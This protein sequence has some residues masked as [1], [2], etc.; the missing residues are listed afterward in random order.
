M[1]MTIKRDFVATVYI[2]KDNKVLLVFHKKLQKW[3]PPGGHISKNELP[4]EAA[5]REAKEETGLDI[6]L[7]GEKQPKFFGTEPLLRPEV[8]QLEDIEKRGHELHQHIDFF[9]IAVPKT[10]CIAVS[11]ESEDIRW[12][13]LKDL[14]REKVPENIRYTA[15]L[16]IE[17]MNN[18]NLKSK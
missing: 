12:F 15:K 10:H 5:I 8:V 11:D 17:K 16:M 14:Q 3:L 1:E 6:E 9:Y 4:D 18:L 13:S 2:I 7:I